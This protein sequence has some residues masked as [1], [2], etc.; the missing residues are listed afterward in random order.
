MRDFDRNRRRANLSEIKSVD[1][2]S[3]LASIG[4]DPVKIRGI[5]Y[6]Y[7]SP[8]RTE[9]TASFKVNRKL[10]RWFDH[11]FGQGGNLVDFLMRFYNCELRDV[12]AMFASDSSLH[13][14]PSVQNSLPKT[15][16]ENSVRINAV[17]PIK[18][19]GLKRYLF[20]RGISFTIACQHCHQVSFSVRLKNYTAIGFANDGGGYE[21]RHVYCKLSSRPKDITTIDYGFDRV[22][23]FEGFFDLLSYRTISN[24]QDEIRKNYVI[25]NSVSLFERARGFLDRHNQIDLYL[26]RDETGRQC[27]QSALAISKKYKDGSGFYDGYKDIN[28]WLM[29]QK[30][31]PI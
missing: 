26:D 15:S 22:A 3:Y 4:I 11:G 27:T 1:M 12:I 24:S 30:Q 9:R 6:W 17:A 29:D 2:V 8:L 16:Q 31:I 5:D 23:V 25:L 28:E 14:Y 19:F 21:L 7:L 18:S 10:N 13:Q 20:R